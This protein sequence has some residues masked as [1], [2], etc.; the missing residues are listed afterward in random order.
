MI[1]A[2]H[3]ESGSRVQEM[4]ML[5]LPLA[6]VVTV[7]FTAGLVAAEPAR[8]EIDTTARAERPVPRRL[9]GKFTEHLWW[10][11][12]NGF[13][14][15]VLKNP[16][17]DP[18]ELMGKSRGRVGQWIRRMGFPA[19]FPKLPTTGV[20]EKTAVPW[21]FAYRGANVSTVIESSGNH[22]LRI[23]A[24]SGAGIEQPIFLPL[25]REQT[26]EM[27]LTAKGDARFRLVIRSTRGEIAAVEVPR[28]G[29]NWSERS[30][31]LAVEAAG[32]QRGALL[33]LRIEL[34]EPGSVT[35]DR[36]VLFPADNV[37]GFDPDIVRMLR[38]SKLPLLRFP[39]GNFVSG[40]H[41]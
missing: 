33:L 20:E 24:G 7:L 34:A 14:A 37:E 18:W 10:N 26:Y 38:A 21:W 29:S 11:V 27:K 9:Y 8:I 28:P 2:D 16:G 22:C 35:L 12:Y 13:W 30:L 19:S 39:G 36:L 31:T 1:A 4:M 23:A 41:W 6:A 15:Q 25:H 32:L 17:F 3:R 40:Y 5:K